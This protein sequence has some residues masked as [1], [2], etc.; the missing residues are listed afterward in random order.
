MTRFNP[1]II[2]GHLSYTIREI[3]KVFGINQK[4]CLRW[5][6]E[7]LA[8]VPGQEKPILIYGSDLK[9]LIRQKNSKK[10]VKMKSRIIRLIEI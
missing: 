9:L 3:V 2:Q 6:A 10:K 1:Q 8:T 7:G 5:I 4:T